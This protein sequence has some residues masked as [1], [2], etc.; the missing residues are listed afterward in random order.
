[1]K[2]SLRELW[3]R[4]PLTRKSLSLALLFGLTLWWLLDGMVLGLSRLQHWLAALAIIVLFT[5][6]NRLNARRIEQLRAR[7]EA[8]IQTE[9]RGSPSALRKGDQIADLERRFGE[10]TA[11]VVHGRD[12][13]R[14]NYELQAHLEQLE[15]LQT[16]TERLGIGVL[17]LKAGHAVPVNNIMRRLANEC[18]GIEHFGG[19][20]GGGGRLE[21]VCQGR[22]QRIFD[23]NSLE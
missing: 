15:V 21:L 22:H 7:V 4:I 6:L 18:G 17:S 11:G 2:R 16:V 8:F 12:A 5:V 14:R 13:L 20:E 1:M 19:L 23:L 9:L 10:L 3:N